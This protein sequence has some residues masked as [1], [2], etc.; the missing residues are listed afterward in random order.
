MCA[1]VLVSAPA[2][3]EWIV[4]AANEFPITPSELSICA[5]FVALGSGF[6]R[7]RHPLF[8]SV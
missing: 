3:C 7:G 6:H 1:G 8:I 4:V 5:R 2:G